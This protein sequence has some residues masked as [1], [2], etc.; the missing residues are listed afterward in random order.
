MDIVI[1]VRG[2]AVEV[3][4]LKKIFVYKYSYRWQLI[5]HF[6]FGYYQESIMEKLQL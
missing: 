1:V 6:V 2:I 3:Q 4:I 5:R